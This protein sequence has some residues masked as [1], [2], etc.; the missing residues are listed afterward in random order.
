[1][2]DIL[3]FLFESYRP[4]MWWYEIIVFFRRLLLALVIGIVP[5][6]SVFKAFC[7]FVVLLL[8]L[9]IQNWLQPYRTSIENRTEELGLVMLIGTFA[10]QFFATTSY[11][12]PVE[13]SEILFVMLLCFDGIFLMFMLVG[14]IRACIARFKCCTR[15]TAKGYR[16]RATREYRR[17]TRAGD[18]SM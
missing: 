7:S 8:S 5:S 6:S 1:M 2:L 15:R 17:P 11:G 9:L 3:G 18:P 4:E 16:Q 13:H 14:L 12:T 10:A